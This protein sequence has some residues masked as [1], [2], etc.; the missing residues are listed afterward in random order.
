MVN[1]VLFDD[2]LELIFIILISFIRSPP[3]ECGLGAT[4]G[5]KYKPEIY[6]SFNIS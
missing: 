2:I 1:K 4:Q 5:T 6:F 3:R